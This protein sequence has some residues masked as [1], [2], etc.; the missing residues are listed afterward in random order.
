M[1]HG[2]LREQDD[3]AVG[4]VQPQGQEGGAVAPV[5]ERIHQAGGGCFAAA[6]ARMISDVGGVY[7]TGES[8][9]AAPSSGC[10]C[11]KRARPHGG[12]TVWLH[13]VSLSS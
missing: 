4:A 2:L 6:S 9:K 13:M 10:R 5:G 3:S 7:A 8:G 11:C 1:Q 12:L